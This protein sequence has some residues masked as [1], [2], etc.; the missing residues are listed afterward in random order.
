MVPSCRLIRNMN[1]RMLLRKLRKALLVGHI[2]GSIQYG[3][4]FT[5]ALI[6]VQRPLIVAVG[7][8]LSIG[9]LVFAA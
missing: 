3:R 6:E 2:V 1:L 4:Q 9:L 8:A 5:C 7:L